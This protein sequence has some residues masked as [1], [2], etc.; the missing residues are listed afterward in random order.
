MKKVEGLLERGDELIVNSDPQD[1]SDLEVEMTELG[2]Y[3]QQIYIRL[4]RLQKRLVS[5]KLVCT[6]IA[7]Y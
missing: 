3:C 4:S 1:A 6:H 7:S 5:T 2:S